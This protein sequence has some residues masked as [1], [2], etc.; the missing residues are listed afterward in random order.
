[1]SWIPLPPARIIKEKKERESLCYFLCFESGLWWSVVTS[2]RRSTLN[3]DLMSLLE[4]LSERGEEGLLEFFREAVDVEAL[5]PEMPQR[6]REGAVKAR[7]L[8]IWGEDHK[9]DLPALMVWLERKEKLL[10][11]MYQR[12]Q[13]K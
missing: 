9:L 13:W 2:L 8:P 7:K 11:A 4:L 3:W 12:M 6:L 5:P 10:G 1:M